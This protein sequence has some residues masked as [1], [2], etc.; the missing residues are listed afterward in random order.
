MLLRG[1]SGCGNLPKAIFFQIV[2][3]KSTIVPEQELNREIIRLIREIILPDMECAPGS[4]Q[5]GQ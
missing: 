1:D 2:G 5:I 4:G 3:Q